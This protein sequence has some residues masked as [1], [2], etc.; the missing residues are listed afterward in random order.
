MAITNYLG[1]LSIRSDVRQYLQHFRPEAEAA[2]DEFQLI[3]IDGGTTSQ[4]LTTVDIN[5]EIGIEGALDVQTMLGIA[6]PTRL[7]SYSTGGSQPKFKP[8]D[9]TPTNNNEP[10]FAWVRYMLNLSDGDLPYVVST[11]YAEDEQT[12]SPEYTE[13]VC[14]SFAQLG[15]RGVSLFFNSGDE[16]VG[17]AGHCVSNNTPHKR[18]FLPTFPSSCPYVTT[19]GATYQVGEEVAALDSRFN[20]TFTSGGGFS[21]MFHTPKYQKDAVSRYLA[22]NNNFPQYEGFFNANGRAYPDVAA[23][24]V[25]FSVVYDGKVIPIDG[26]SASAPAFAAVIALVND[27]LLAEGK[28]TMGFLNP[29]L[30]GGGHKAFT[31][32]TSGSSA[33][34]EVDGFP[35]TH[36]WDAVTG[37]GTP[38]FRDILE[39]LGLARSG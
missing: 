3:A 7:I 33:G 2:A 37:Y 19:V 18:R 13:R 9:F 21:D 35:A 16:G 27:A 4:T 20:I 36:G 6:W 34:C 15:V 29:W 23:Q 30:Y 5:R 10:Y 17:A 32:I 38:N 1:E 31:D 25:N 22:A 8:D 12:V 11:S 24:G 28:S 26:T 39:S 14:N